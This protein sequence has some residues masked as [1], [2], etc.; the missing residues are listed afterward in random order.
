MSLVEPARR[1]FLGAVLILMSGGLCRAA[2]PG[3]ARFEQIAR[4]LLKTYCYECHSG[5][6]NE[7]RLALDQLTADSIG[8]RST[9]DAWWSV[10]K[11]LRAGIM[12]PAGHSRPDKA[13][14]EAIA[15]GIKFDLLGIDPQNPDPGRITVR[16]LNRRE[17]GNTI[18]DLMGLQFDAALLFPPDD[19]G[20]GF[21]NV[22]DALSFSP[23]LMEKYLRAAQSIVEQAVPRTTWVIPNRE[24]SGRDFV[25]AQG[26]D[27]A[28]RITGKKMK[29]VRCK[30]TMD[31]AGS[32][33]VSVVVKLHGTF[34]FDPSRYS[35]V[36]RIDNQER[37]Q[38]VY[39]WDENKA[40]RSQFTEDWRPGEHELS[41]ELTP[42][43]DSGDL[44]QKLVGID[45]GST[46]VFFE[47]NSVLI[48]GPRGTAKRVHPR[49]Y[50]KFFPRESPPDSPNE[51]HA[52]AEEI[53]RKFATRAFRGPVEQKTLD[54]LVKLAESVS[55][56]PDRT[57]EAG[58]AHAM[59][60]ALSSPRFLFRLESTSAR[61]GGPYSEIDELSLASRLSYFFWSTMPDEELFR[62]ANAGQLR[63]QLP[64]QVKRMLADRRSTEFVRNFVGQWLR[65]RDV[66]QVT[67]DP[68]AVL[69]HQEEYEKLREQ[70]RNRRRQP[71]GRELTP[72]DEQIRKRFGEFR[73]IADRFNDEMKRAM[74]RETEL[75]VEHIVQEDRS[76]LDLLDCD[77]AFVNEKLAALY[78][79]PGVR[80]HEFRRVNLPKESPRGGVLTQAS[81]LM[82]TSNP[83]RT[84]PVKRGLFILENILGTPAL[85]A[86]PGVPALEESARKF[87]D[88][89]PPLREL[90]AAHRESAICA[91]CHS[92]M[93]PLGLALENFNALGMW[94][95]Q[96][97][98]QKIDASGVMVTGEPFQDIRE[99]KKILR[100]RHATDFYRCVAEKMLVYALGRGLEITD[101]HSIDLI[102]NRL[103][104]NGGR[105][106][107]LVQGVVDSAPFQ[108]RRNQGL[109]STV[110]SQSDSQ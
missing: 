74:Q 57:F 104:E 80:G 47:I 42:L 34:D 97:K 60:A 73:S 26:L 98:G 108:K 106:S 31:E 37:S 41:F 93:D 8:T 18:Q 2:N 71:L 91:S 3:A 12:P 4:P 55:S 79:I 107:S 84:S 35:V 40:Y 46:D 62:L 53:M 30:F 68:I 102:V 44:D 16:R 88:R 33:D 61:E 87:S 32:Y 11:N 86:P 76:L 65:T 94:R 22:G 17:Y 10:L 101:E 96:E 51:R 78:D 21:D 66:T 23:L 1:L 103:V 72:E 45:R 5:N 85:P 15:N 81:M 89:E 83:T 7:G 82:V 70:F 77:Y 75:S 29:L 14:Q 39:G 56:R 109:S 13:E 43:P 20:F 48:E 59:A 38:A 6:V 63:Q 28:G 24:F 58:I 25:D 90:L 50:A 36:F 27:A 95:D 110:S 105:F 54:G 100:D 99:L 19:S 9:Q 64:Q 67:V 52:Y 69:G 92:R 49:N